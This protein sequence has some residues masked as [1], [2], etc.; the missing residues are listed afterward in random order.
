MLKFI[1]VVVTANLNRHVCR[2][3]GFFSFLT[4]DI[5]VN[6]KTVLIIGHLQSIISVRLIT[7]KNELCSIPDHVMRIYSFYGFEKNITKVQACTQ[8]LRLR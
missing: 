1:V 8:P 5:K 2:C 3:K 7:E 4:C 6:C